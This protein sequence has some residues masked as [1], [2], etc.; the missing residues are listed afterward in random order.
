MTKCYSYYVQQTCGA[1]AAEAEPR[2]KAPP[3]GGAFDSA[4]VASCRTFELYL[5]LRS[6]CAEDRDSR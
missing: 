1:R 6:T 2:T 4:P 3:D 5:L